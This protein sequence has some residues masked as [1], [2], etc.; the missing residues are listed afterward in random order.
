MAQ[1]RDSTSAT[2]APRLS[3]LSLDYEKP[4]TYALG[5]KTSGL[6]A[7]FKSGSDGSIFVEM[8]GLEGPTRGFHIYRL[9][10]SRDAVRLGEPNVEGLSSFSLPASYFVTSSKTYVLRQ[11][12]IVD[13]SS[14]ISSTAS[15][16]VVVVY[17]GDGS[18]QNVVRLDPDI[19][20][21]SVGAFG[22]GDLL[23]L[24]VDKLNHST[25]LLKFDT[26]GRLLGELRLFD[27]DYGAKLALGPKAT[28]AKVGAY[29]ERMLAN[30]QFLPVGDN[31]LIVPIQTRLPLLEINEHGVVRSTQLALPAG[32][33]LSAVVPSDDG[34]LHVQLDQSSGDAYALSDDDFAKGKTVAYQADPCIYDFNASDGS[35]VDRVSFAKELIPLR[36]DG[37]DFIFL[38]TRPEDG[39]L[40]VVKGSI[41]R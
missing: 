28:P 13:L 41:A 33:S 2:N 27:E 39:H 7:D 32:K 18:I 9:K 16:Y 36:K 5:S 21:V 3:T 23:V 11:A 22:S 6:T 8:V 10:P 38:T 15:I 1:Q 37:A 30:A 20:P 35:L 31:I 24:S 19:H 40:Q 34:M 25:R 14:Q 4:V 29:L 12:T 26:E 17:D